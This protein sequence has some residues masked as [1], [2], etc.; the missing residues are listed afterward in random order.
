MVFETRCLSV[1]VPRKRWKGNL[2][3]VFRKGKAEECGSYAAFRLSS[4]SGKTMRLLVRETTLRPMENGE[5]IGNREHG[6]PKC[7][8]SIPGGFG[9]VL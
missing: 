3:P 6:V 9:A 4:V 7:R 1:Q 8:I 5:V 2:S